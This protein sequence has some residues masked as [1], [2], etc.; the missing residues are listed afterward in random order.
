MQH[1]SDKN[2]NLAINYAD[3]SPCLYV[4]RKAVPD[5]LRTHFISI[6]QSLTPV[7]SNC[8]TRR[9]RTVH[10]GPKEFNPGKN[11]AQFYN[12]VKRV[13]KLDDKV[14][15]AHVVAMLPELLFANKVLQK[16]CP[17]IH[18]DCLTVCW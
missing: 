13:W 12:G 17:K 9:V 10:L 1:I 14:Q 8:A 3:G 5:I 16:V 2:T 7:Y 18:T 15:K 6:A 4:F 11:Q